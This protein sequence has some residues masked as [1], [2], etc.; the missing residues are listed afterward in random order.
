MVF[1]FEI[2]KIFQTSFQIRSDKT[3][4]KPQKLKTPHEAGLSG[5]SNMAESEGFEPPVGCPTSDFKSGAFGRTLPTLLELRGMI[6]FCN[7][8]STKNLAKLLKINKKLVF[9]CLLINFSFE[10]DFILLIYINRN[11]NNY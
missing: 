8:V 9:V 7:F 2:S 3:V 1:F 5:R 6:P 11:K 10:G 4:L